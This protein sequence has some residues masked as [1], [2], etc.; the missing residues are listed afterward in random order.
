MCFLFGWM[1]L[2]WKHLRIA[3]FSIFWQEFD[4]KSVPIRWIVGSN[5]IFCQ[6][7]DSWIL[8]SWCVEVL[9]FWEKWGVYGQKTTIWRGLWWF[10]W[11]ILLSLYVSQGGAYINGYVVFRPTNDEILIFPA[12]PKNTYIWRGGKWNG[13]VK[14][15]TEEREGKGWQ[16]IWKWV[17]R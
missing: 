12:R 9:R 17:S 5:Q 10:L 15:N 6:G 7:D 16:V 2:N 3:N 13:G 8:E 14:R 4:F 11:P 1:D